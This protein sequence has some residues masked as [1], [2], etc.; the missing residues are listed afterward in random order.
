MDRRRWGTAAVAAA[1]LALL[2]GCGS[3]ADNPTS[4]DD[5]AAD[6]ADTAD[7]G[8]EDDAGGTTAAGVADG[9]ADAV[10]S[11]DGQDYPSDPVLGFEGGACRINED[12]DRPGR[13]FVAYFAASG[14][15]VELSFLAPLSDMSDASDEDP[16]LGSLN[17]GGTLELSLGSSEPWP[18]TDGDGSTISGAFTMEDR[19]GNPAEVTFDITCP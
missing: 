5:A 10:V 16:F 17:I 15:R 4:G 14:E 6:A 12:P 8:T 11:V 2:V 13:A 19:D 1:V 7:V 3:D 18:W 9:A